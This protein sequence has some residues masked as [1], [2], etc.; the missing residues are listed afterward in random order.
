M[1]AVVVVIRW[2]GGTKLGTGGLARAYGAVAASA[3]DAARVCSVV[4][5]EVRH[6][7]YGFEDTGTVA[8]VLD[9]LGAT[10]GP[11]GYDA[12]PGAA[13]RTEIRLPRDLVARLDAHLREATGG[14][15][16]VEPAE[17]PESC[18]VPE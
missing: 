9:A 3:L 11:D 18:W 2:F 17:E 5:G 16:G 1:D 6:V 8:R 4:R 13:V 15:V 10:R 12:G 14:R 7:R